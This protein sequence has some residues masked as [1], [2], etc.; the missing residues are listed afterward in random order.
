MDIVDRILKHVYCVAA[1]TLAGYFAFHTLKAERAVV[2]ELHE[3]VRLT[4]AEAD[5]GQ[6]NEIQPDAPVSL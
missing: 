6:G 2:V 1:L 3:L 5:A 4:A